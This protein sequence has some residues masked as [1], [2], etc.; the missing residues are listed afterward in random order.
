MFEDVDPDLIS[1]DDDGTEYATFCIEYRFNGGTFSAE[2][3]ASSF[4]DAGKRVEALVNCILSGKADLLLL[5][6]RS[7]HH[8]TIH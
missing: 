7:E 2:I 8:G 3:E 4:E 5:T 6:H 1:V